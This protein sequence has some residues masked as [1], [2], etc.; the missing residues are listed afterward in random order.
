[1]AV[2]PIDLRSRGRVLLL[3]VRGSQCRGRASGRRPCTAESPAR[4]GD[5][6]RRD[7]GKL[8]SLFPKRRVWSARIRVFARLTVVAAALAAVAAGA[9]AADGDPVDLGVTA[10]GS[11]QFRRHGKQLAPELA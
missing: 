7:G 2:P 10:S 9:A 8:M 4:P 1:G 6:Q 3:P 11:A 5:D